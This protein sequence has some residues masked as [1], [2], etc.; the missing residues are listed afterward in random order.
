MSALPGG[1]GPVQA[2]QSA[3]ANPAA[4]LPDAPVDLQG[5]VAAMK[6][7][8][9]KAIAD[10]LQAAGMGEAAALGALDAM[11][12]KNR[13]TAARFFI[14][15]M[16]LSDNEIRK[17]LAGIDLTEP[18]EI[19]DVPPPDTM[20]QFV[21]IGPNPKLGD[22]F[23]AGQSRT[24]DEIGLNI[25]PAKRQPVT[26]KIPPGKMLKSKAAPIVDDWTDRGV[27]E[28]ITRG[29]GEQYVSS[30]DVKTAMQAGLRGTGMYR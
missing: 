28:V 15:E 22:F 20:V 2:A 5:C 25:D 23:A 13:S 24:G 1:D 19:V 27:T 3:I 18:V 6:A 30:K 21:R 29:G 9:E 12:E 16:G 17:L 10:A 4:I 7:R 14:E 8:K 26:V 11:K